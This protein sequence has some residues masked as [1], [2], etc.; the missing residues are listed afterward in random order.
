MWNPRSPQSQGPGGRSCSVHI[1][2]GIPSQKLSPI[3]R[4]SFSVGHLWRL[5]IRVR[6]ARAALVGFLMAFFLP[7]L[8]TPLVR[9]QNVGHRD[10]SYGKTGDA[11]LTGERPESKL[12]WNDGSWWGSLFDR[13]LSP[14]TST[15][16][17]RPPKPGLTRER[18][19]T[20]APGPRRM[21]FGTARPESSTSSRI[22]LAVPRKPP[23]PRPIGPGSTACP[24]T[25]R[26]KLTP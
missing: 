4:A 24:T 25:G 18:P 9:A 12:W 11:K 21:R 13:S 6:V 17:M 1:V 14:T 23:R 3:E 15:G 16:S 22:F 7:G 19:W 8:G 5:R 2:A 10:F 26:R 20:A